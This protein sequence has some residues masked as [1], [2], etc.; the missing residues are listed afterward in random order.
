MITTKLKRNPNP[1]KIIKN[2]P[3]LLGSSNVSFR[4]KKKLAKHINALDI[5]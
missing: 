4:H 3:I 2:I 1:Q 5:E